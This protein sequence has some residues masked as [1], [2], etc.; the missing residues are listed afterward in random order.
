MST[1]RDLGLKPFSLVIL[2]FS[3]Y[4][5]RTYCSQSKHNKM[6]DNAVFGASNYWK[7]IH[8]SNK[9]QRLYAI[10]SRVKVALVWSSEYRDFINWVCFWILVVFSLC[11][12]FFSN[13]IM[14]SFF[15]SRRALNVVVE[16]ITRP[17]SNLVVK[18]GIGLSRNVDSLEPEVKF[19]SMKDLFLSILGVSRGPFIT[20]Q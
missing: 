5:F 3:W 20:P 18:W 17:A 13:E 1:S 2:F 6:L 14:K 19:L 4:W 12:L 16:W 11:T 7:L 10:Y 9:S 15:F 8:L